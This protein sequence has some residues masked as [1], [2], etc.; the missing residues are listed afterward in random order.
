MSGDSDYFEFPDPRTANSEGVVA[1]GGVI[2]TGC[3]YSA[4]LQGIFPWPVEFEDEMVTAWCSPDPRAV[5]LWDQI[6]IP[7]RLA[8][9]IRS[10]R[11]VVTSDQ[12]FD[13]VVNACAGPRVIEGVEE[14][15]T[16]ITGEMR[17][18][19]NELFTMGKT[20]SVEVWEED[21][22]VGGLYGVS[23]GGIF[24][25]ESMFRRVSDA[26]KVGL[27][28]LLRHLQQQGYVLMDLQQMTAHC[29]SLG[30]V[31]INRQ[32]YLEVLDAS[33]KR[34]VEFGVIDSRSHSW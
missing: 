5:F 31:M 21:V 27:C 19:Y 13:A 34:P 25:G 7:R 1:V 17:A 26:S 6:H 32:I 33:L 30:A 20:H 16:W 4:Y 23:V 3:V 24:A 18:V 22:L 28:V 14:H 2:D 9:K 8:R 10:R 12:A 11:F 15:G 29:A